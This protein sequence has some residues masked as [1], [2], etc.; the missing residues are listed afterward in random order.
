M[1]DRLQDKV[2]IVAGA[3]QS[4]GETIGNGRA[5]AILFAR[6][7]AKVMLLD[8][9]LESAQETL[10]M[11]EKEGGQAIVL[12]AD[13]TSEEDCR[14]M[15]ETCLETWGRI[16]IL[17]N[18]VGIGE[19]GKGFVD[20]PLAD[21]QR[22]M[23]VNLTGMYLTCQQVMPH[24]IKQ[25][26]GV[27]INISS[28]ASLMA[29]G[30]LAYKA[31]KAGVNALTHGLAMEAA[32]YGVRVNAILP[33]LMETPMAIEGRVRAY[34]MS[35]EEVVRPRNERVPLKGGMGSGW[36]VAHAA[37]FL[38]SDEAK[39]ITGVLLPVDGGQIARIG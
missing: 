14:R 23:N 35:R 9:R 29:T 20:I 31:S 5:T 17:H 22:F 3:G 15:A 13:V 27:I 10:A 32:P 16:D 18:N 7:G 4:P 11:I 34:G 2:A 24:M 26:S 25:G 30:A 19:R 8:N 6:E 36:D 39:F 38:A 21:W 37:L 12:Q 33:G 1:A 28:I